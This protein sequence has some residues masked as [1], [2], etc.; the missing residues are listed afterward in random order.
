MPRTPNATPDAAADQA[1][2]APQQLDIQITL[3][4][5]TI[6]DLKL[7]GA[8]QKGTADQMEMI[9]L[10]ARC[11]V[12]GIDH[13]PFTALPQIAQALAAAMGDASNP[14]N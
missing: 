9:D 6:G 4:A 2:A 12:G 1:A 7:F 14:K 13:L 10:L 3:D 8:L 11:V 5:L